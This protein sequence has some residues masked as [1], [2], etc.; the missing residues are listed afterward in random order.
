MNRTTTD[1]PSPAIEVERVSKRFGR[2]WALRD[3]TFAVPRGTIFGLL[4]HNGAGKSTLLGALLG[5]LFPD[6]GRLRIGGADVF[7]RRGEALRRVGAI[8]ETPA[9]YD[10]LSGRRN[11]ELLCAYSARPERARIEAAADRVGLADDLDRPVRA[12][13]HGMRQR[14]ALAQAL[15]PDPDVLILDE[16]ADGLD[17]EGLMEFRDLLRHLNR[18][19]GRTIL[20]S[21]HLLSEVRELCSHVAVLRQGNVVYAGP[22]RNLLADERRVTLRLMPADRARAGL[23]SAGLV[24]EWEDEETARLA[25]GAGVPDVVRWCVREGIEVRAAAPREL[26]LEDLYV[27]WM[28]S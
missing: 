28:R 26:S 10:Y 15:L 19:R 12:Y 20:L 6:A 27:R 1:P 2:R 8:F 22:L 4:G 18:E 7:A 25:P 13:S 23:A 5:Q 14:L 3:V 11:L 9:F 24:E 16:P 21:S 17:P